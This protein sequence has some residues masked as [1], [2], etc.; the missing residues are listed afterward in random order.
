MHAS[1]DG[2]VV[3]YPLVH[4]LNPLG[5]MSSYRHTSCVCGQ[6]SPQLC[7][8]ISITEHLEC[9]TRGNH[10]FSVLCMYYRVY[11]IYVR[12][13]LPDIGFF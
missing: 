10:V 9:N 11:I 2:G 12:S 4:T 5:S 6:F 8:N 3:S 7:A 1:N 13:A